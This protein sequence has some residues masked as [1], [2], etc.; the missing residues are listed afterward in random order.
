MGVE[1]RKLAYQVSDDWDDE[2]MSRIVF[3]DND[4]A[5]EKAFDMEVDSLIRKPQYDEYEELGYVPFHRLYADGWW[6]TCWHCESRINDDCESPVIGEEIAWCS[7]QCKDDWEA[8]KGR[9]RQKRR[10]AEE[11]LRAKYPFVN[12]IRSWVGGVGPCRECF[13]TDRENIAIKFEFA[14]SKT[15]NNSY[16]HGCKRTWICNGDADAW[17][18]TM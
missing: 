18:N 13:D 15:N 10:E 5:S 2:D 6:F 11:A 1:M 17:K 8:R 4:Q 3:L 12:N 16:C 9:I 14:G 7:Q